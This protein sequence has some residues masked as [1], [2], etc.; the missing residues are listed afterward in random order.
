M[1]ISSLDGPLFVNS[2]VICPQDS[3]VPIIFEEPPT[4]DT[5]NAH[6]DNFVRS[7]PLPHIPAES[8]LS[9]SSYTS[10]NYNRTSYTNSNWSTNNGDV[11]RMS[12]NRGRGHPSDMT[13][14]EDVLYSERS[15][16]SP[17][18]S[19]RNVDHRRAQSAPL[20]WNEEKRIWTFAD[21]ISINTSTP[22]GPTL[23]PPGPT[24]PPPGPTLLPPGPTSPPPEPSSPPPPYTY[25]QTQTPISQPPA[26]LQTLTPDRFYHNNAHAETEH[27]ESNE[28]VKL[29]KW[30]AVARRVH[31]RM[32]I[33]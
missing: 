21:Y 4:P 3:T 9:Q 20:I 6:Y 19:Y 31:N 28:G 13:L 8:T 27:N 22:P 15:R 14:R 24:L 12:A 1:D 2:R 30:N 32:S 18:F 11:R 10:N 29:S 25:Y 33:G 5:E 16:S 26:R 7:K 23:P 17:N